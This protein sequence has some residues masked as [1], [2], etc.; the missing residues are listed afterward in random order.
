MKSLVDLHARKLARGY[1]L[2]ELLFALT[3]ITILLVTLGV[4]FGGCYVVAHFI[5]KAW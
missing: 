5:G 2:S 4:S 1:T 3:L